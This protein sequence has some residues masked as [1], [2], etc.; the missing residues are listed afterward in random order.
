METVADKV[1]QVKEKVAKTVANLLFKKETKKSKQSN[2]N[3]IDEEASIEQ[4]V[5]LTGNMADI[6]KSVANS[7]KKVTKVEKNNNFNLIVTL[8]SALVIIAL[9]VSVGYYIIKKDTEEF[10]YESL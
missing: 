5:Q 6:E 3:E 7:S 10:S 8:I 4:E 2:N 1:A 9:G